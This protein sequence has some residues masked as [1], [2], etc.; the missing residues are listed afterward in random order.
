MSDLAKP[1]IHLLTESD[2]FF[3]QRLMP[4]ESM[5]VDLIE[6]ILSEH[7]SVCRVS[8][9]EI[10]SGK[11]SL[12][13]SVIVH[14]SSQQPDYKQFIDDVLLYLH[15]TGNRLVPS[16]HATRSHE[17]KG[18]QQLHRRLRG[19]E[20]L[21]PGYFAKLS[22][23]D[24]DRI[25]FP[26]VFKDVAGFGSSGVQLVRAK[27]ELGKAA[28]AERRFSWR[29]TRRALRRRLGYFIRKRVLRRDVRWC[30]NYYKRMKRFVLQEYI[31]GLTHDFK[32]LTFQ[33]RIFLVRRDVRPNDFRASGSGLLYF[34]DPPPGLLDFAY[35]LLRKFDEPYMSFDICFDG[36]RFHLLEFQGVHF[37]PLVVLESRRHFQRRDG[38]WTECT[39]HVELENVIGESLVS[40]LKQVCN[41]G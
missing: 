24:L 29:E 1:P 3:G 6:R 17:N 13:D 37:G 19:I 11:V 22:E 25:D 9:A 20:A 23:L 8:Y 36:S 2:G 28:V 16:I 35:E 41:R 21:K 32:V 27:S 5:D 30:G 15:A 31:P 18:Y 14:S 26:I 34:D 7:F 4:W 33:D 38:R 12:I 39:D 10:A 40:Y